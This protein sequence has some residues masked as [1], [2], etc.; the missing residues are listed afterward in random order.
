[1]TTAAQRSQIDLNYDVFQRT[2]STILPKHRNEYALMR[3]REIVGFFA[4]AGDAYRAGLARYSDRVFSI[5]EV[6]DEPVDLGLF[7]H[8]HGD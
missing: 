2:L 4:S 5:Q 8:V 6:T 1:M 3:D 7:S